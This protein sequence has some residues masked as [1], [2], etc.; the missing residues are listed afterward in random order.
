M[1]SPLT[2]KLHR[3]VALEGLDREAL[4]SLSAQ[5]AKL[6]SKETLV[7]EGE[8]CVSIY[9]FVSGWACRFKTVPGKSRQIIGFLVPGDHVAADHALAHRLDYGV[10][11]LTDCDVI[12]VPIQALQRLVEE[13]PGIDHGLRWAALAD[14]ATLR[15]WLLGLGRRSA[16]KRLAHLFCELHTRLESVGLADHNSFALPLTQTTLGDAL[17]LSPAHVNRSLQSLRARQFVSFAAGLVEIASVERLRKFA[18]FDPRYLQLDVPSPG[19][20]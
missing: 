2:K 5:T 9:F 14:V 12:E 17:G 18:G 7:S 20:D 8:R 10:C 16:E 4:D 1:S 11:T 6:P 19:L 3:G 15:E 13:R